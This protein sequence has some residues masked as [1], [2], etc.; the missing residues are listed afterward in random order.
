MRARA[1]PHH[2][3]ED[4]GP[5]GT[6]WGEG[7]RARYGA[8]VL[9]ALGTWQFWLDLATAVGTV[10]AV[11]VAVVLATRDWRERRRNQASKI[12]AY[13]GSMDDRVVEVRGTSIVISN[14]SEAGIYDVLVGLAGA[15]GGLS[16]HVPQ[17]NTR[18]LTSVPPG[19]W[20]LDDLI[21]DGEAM[22]VRFGVL[23]EF[24]D[25]QGRR[26][27]RSADGSF[28]AASGEWLRQVRSDNKPE[29]QSIRRMST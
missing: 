3:R 22:N 16:P 8:T 20:I 23:I 13:F 29:S 14:G 4:H 10:G 21:Y 6:F 15:W 7:G 19:D 24:T 12:V 2:S 5:R 1:A 9:D 25:A 18:W 26:W 11:V 17:F 28:Q 27:R